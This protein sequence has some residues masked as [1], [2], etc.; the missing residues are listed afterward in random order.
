MNWNQIMQKIVK[1]VRKEATHISQVSVI[2]AVLNLGATMVAM[3]KH[4]WFDLGG[5]LYRETT[6]FEKVHDRHRYS[7]YATL[8]GEKDL[9][10]AKQTYDELY[11]KYGSNSA[12]FSSLG[13]PS[14][15]WQKIFEKM[16]LTEFIKSDKT[17][18]ETLAA[19]KDLVPISLFT[20]FRTPRIH[21]VLACL[22]I[23]PMTLIIF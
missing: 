21:E 14:D 6:A 3:I 10:H 7:A 16:D 22:E 9:A 19:V 5:T 11:K 13:K 15:Y 1:A 4:V 20:N 18:I 12:V 2:E 23:P 8:V 17:V